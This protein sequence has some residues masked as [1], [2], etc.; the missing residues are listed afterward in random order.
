MSIKKEYY[1]YERIFL[2]GIF[3]R[4]RKRNYDDLLDD[5]TLGKPLEYYKKINNVFSHN[6]VFN[7]TLFDFVEA[8]S[9]FAMLMIS[10]SQISFSNYER[11]IEYF[12]Y[13][14]FA[15]VEFNILY[16]EYYNKSL[17]QDDTKKRK[18]SQDY[19]LNKDFS[20]GLPNDG[21]PKVGLLKNRY[22]ISNSAKTFLETTFE[23]TCT[24]I[25]KFYLNFKPQNNQTVYK[26]PSE[27]SA[28]C[29]Y[30]KHGVKD[31]IKKNLCPINVETYIQ[32]AHRIIHDPKSVKYNLNY[33]TVADRMICDPESVKND[34]TVFKLGKEKVI[35]SR[36]INNNQYIISYI[37]VNK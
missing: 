16:Y 7:Q 21:L 27:I 18:L 4:N 19:V 20:D 1:Q 33:R 9:S 12:Y 31:Q 34:P 24:E 10:Q 32:D 23:K 17:E 3:Y 14:E 2:N 25:D 13:F 5:I 15:M 29:H 26:F 11:F 22:E 28:V 8:A 36:K 35:L 37:T 30:R 6:W